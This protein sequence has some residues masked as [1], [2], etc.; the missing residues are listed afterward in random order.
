[1]MLICP[2]SYARI[3]QDFATKFDAVVSYESVAD[4]LRSRGDVTSGE[5]RRRLTFRADLLDQAIHK[6]RR[7]YTPVPNDVIGSFNQRYVALLAQL[8]PEIVPGK[9]MLGDAPP[10]ESVSMIYD[11]VKSLNFLN[12]DIRPRRFAHELGRNH[13]HR[14]NYVAVLSADGDACCGRLRTA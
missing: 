6:F 7:G 5:T 9:T 4:F 2:V 1:M 12:E 8:A 3:H 10:D 13:D 11:H 14:A